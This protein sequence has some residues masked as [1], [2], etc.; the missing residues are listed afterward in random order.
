MHLELI[1]CGLAVLANFDSPLCRG[2]RLRNHRAVAE[3]Y[4][5]IKRFRILLVWWRFV[6]VTVSS[7]A[8]TMAKAGILLS[9]CYETSLSVQ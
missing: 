1:L 4:N 5:F 6:Y 2:L 7:I 9:A 3:N 8:T